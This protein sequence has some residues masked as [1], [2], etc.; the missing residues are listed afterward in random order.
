MLE[1]ESIIANLIVGQHLH[2]RHCPKVEKVDGVVQGQTWLK[3]MKFQVNII[4]LNYKSIW[5]AKE[6]GLNS[7]NCHNEQISTIFLS[8]YPSFVPLHMYLWVKNSINVFQ[9][10]VCKGLGLRSSQIVAMNMYTKGLPSWFFLF[11]L[12]ISIVYI[13]TKISS[14]YAFI[15]RNKSIKQFIKISQWTSM[16]FYICTTIYLLGENSINVF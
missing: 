10:L 14:Y 2:W 12:C 1:E 13:W 15:Y 16:Y 8:F 11:L 5:D 4:E 6:L 3:G 9:S 7:S